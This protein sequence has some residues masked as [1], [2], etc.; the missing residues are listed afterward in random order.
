MH[1][2]TPLTAAAEALADGRPIE[3]DALESSAANEAELQAI[4]ALR[5][6]S[7]AVHPGDTERPQAWGRL[8]VIERIGSG[9]SADV[10]RAW[11]PVLDR[12]VALKVLTRDDATTG[13]H[14]LVVQEGRLLARVK[15]PNVVSVFGAERIGNSIGIW[16]EFVQGRTLEKLLHDF[17]CLGADEICVI[18][19]QLSRAL[20]A[21]HAAGLLHR[22]IKA[23]NVMRDD[24]GRIVLMDLGAG[25]EAVA[26]PAANRTDQ[27]GTPL[28]LAPEVLHG[29]AASVRSDVYSL[30][31][32]LY[33]LATKS[34]PVLATT[35]DDLRQAHATRTRARL[36][37]RRP[38]LPDQLVRVI[39]RA[40]APEPARR[41]ESAGALEA[42]LVES[43]TEIESP[44]R[45]AGR[46]RA[47]VTALLAVVMLVLGGL[48]WRNDE[49]PAATRGV[50]SLAV[51]PLQARGGD[52]DYF[53]QGITE[54]LSSR[55]AR[56]G[57]TRVIAHTSTMQY[58]NGDQAL[59]H[60][61]RELNVDALVTGSVGRTNGRV[62]LE[63]RLVDPSSGRVLWKDRFDAPVDEAPGLEARA[64]DAIAAA[65]EGR[66]ARAPL[67]SADTGTLDPGAH[68]AYLRGRYF[69]NQRRGD[70]LLKSVPL[71][72]QALGLSPTYAHAYSGLADA[73]ILLGAYGVLPMADAYPKARAAALQALQLDDTLAEAHV[74]LAAVAAEYEWNT[75]A[76]ERHFKSAIAL[77]PGYSLAHQWYA[78]LLSGMM[79][80]DEAIR[81]ATRAY[82]LDPLS[83]MV[84]VSRAVK[85]YE[86]RRYESAIRELKQVVLLH[87]GFAPGYT[88]LGMAYVKTGA[89]ADAIASLREAQRLGHESSTD[90]HALLGYAYAAAGQHEQARAILK[91]LLAAKARQPVK[92]FT[93]ATIY[94][95]L[96]DLDVAFKWLERAYQDREWLIPYMKTLPTLDALRNDPRFEAF[97]TR[98]GLQ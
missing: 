90:I 69:L 97:L 18:A 10:Y 46:R 85:F 55:L 24:L 92:A 83:P 91:D 40:I 76:A 48:V 57:S 1:D 47:L 31:V 44:I 62:I 87:P 42:A 52:A 37:D 84:Q 79:R 5:R 75:T 86:A 82:E 74:A 32:L 29:E 89:F 56:T 43:L 59:T 34:Y 16:M 9:A 17:G 14:E 2:Q 3:W 41:F 8:R 12:E 23:Q 27:T 35:V 80:H 19:L 45:A 71:F 93:I 65:V 7:D 49:A 53:A 15:H 70:T 67:E 26:A 20:A 30:G 96:G 4:R 54:S 58:R 78:D 22:D 38:D 95:E 68:E 98:V 63:A 36:R 13:D 94:A 64:A 6:V 88:H 60:I 39:E 77:N 73:F 28:Y 72:E 33:H 11:D 25:R 66:S 50:T 81:E 61:A 51:L 21:V